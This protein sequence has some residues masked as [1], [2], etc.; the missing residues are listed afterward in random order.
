MLGRIILVLMG[1]IYIKLFN[2]LSLILQNNRK[3]YTFSYSIAYNVTCNQK[4]K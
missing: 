2:S 4:W 3:K 1:Y